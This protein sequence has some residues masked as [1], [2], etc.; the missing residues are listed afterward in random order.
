M[1]LLKVSLQSLSFFLISNWKF[2][3]IYEEEKSEHAKE[4]VDPFLAT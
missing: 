1:I 2:E 3:K 4:M